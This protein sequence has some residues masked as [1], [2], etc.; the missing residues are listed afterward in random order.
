IEHRRGTDRAV[1][2][3]DGGAALLELGRELLRRRAVERVAV[4]FGR[5]L[6]G[7]RQIGKTSYG[8]DRGADLVEIAKRLEDEQVD[9]AVE[10][11]PPLLAEVLARLV[12]AGPPPRLD[13]YPQRSNRSRDV[14]L[15][16]R[17]MARDLRR[18]LV[19]RVQPIGEAER[20][21]LDAVRAERVRLDDVGA[22]PDAFLVH[23]GAQIRLRQVQRV[24]ALVDEDALRVE[25]RPHRAVANE[26]PLVERV[27]KG[28]HVSR[29][30]VLN[31]SES[32]S[33]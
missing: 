16:A 5:H 30:S 9:A 15:V 10:E 19:D 17:R 28:F 20:S 1:D 29:R 24:E 13:P 31:V 27:E 12:D 11:R 6:G 25:H 18:L 21:E 32:M 8:V 3:D 23:F 2:A 26:D 7:D 33:K 14:R 4:L 22:G